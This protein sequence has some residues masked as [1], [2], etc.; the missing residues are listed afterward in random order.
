[1]AFL[2]QRN[3]PTFTGKP[4]WR[5]GMVCHL[6]RSRAVTG[7]FQPC[8]SVIKDGRRWRVPD[9]EGPIPNYFPAIISEDL[10][11][12]GRLGVGERLNHHGNRKIPSYRNL[13]VRLARCSVCRGPLYLF[14]SAGWSYLRCGARHYGECT[15][16]MGFPHRKLESV[17]FALGRLT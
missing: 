2:N 7:L 16:A 3:V 14:D 11:K 13:V 9:P 17:L 8:L 10:Y 4:Y 6:L 15:N 1:A 5:V 12:Q